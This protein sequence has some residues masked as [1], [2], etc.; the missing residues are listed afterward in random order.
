M[1]KTILSDP[2]QEACR[3]FLPKKVFGSVSSVSFVAD[4]CAYHLDPIIR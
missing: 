2:G 3:K 1:L 4:P